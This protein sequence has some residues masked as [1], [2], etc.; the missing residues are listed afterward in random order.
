MNEL[1]KTGKKRTI[2]ISA[3]VL[4]VSIHTI[5]FYHAGRPEIEVNKL[6]QQGIRFLLTVGLLIAAYQGKT[7]A[8]SIAAVLFALAIVAAL[9]GLAKIEGPMMN[10][11]P[12]FVMVFVYSMAVYH[13]GFSKSY[14]AFFDYQNKEEK[15]DEV[16][17]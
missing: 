9:I 7:W 3:S 11:T 10:K 1:I 13:F 17:E 5:F 14:R 16:Q 6:L 15:V 4:L 2:L 12:I 8:K